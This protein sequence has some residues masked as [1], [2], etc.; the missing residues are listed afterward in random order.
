M[1][2]PHCSSPDVRVVESRVVEDGEAIRRRRECMSCHTR[3]T[4]YERIV[5]SRL[6]VIKRTGDRESYDQEKVVRGMR[7][8]L[9]NRP[10]PP[11]EIRRLA[12]VVSTRLR[13]RGDEV[14]S[15]EIG[16]EV[17]AVLREV[18]EV[19]YLRFASVYKNFTEADD[20]RREVSEID[21]GFRLAKRE[22]QR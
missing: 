11:E 6:M 1:R 5:E 13:R 7:S 22:E 9:K 15:S 8:A 20:F 16:V 18:D 3:F 21:A 12:D 14:S 2:C 10:V 19:G 17:L 4:T